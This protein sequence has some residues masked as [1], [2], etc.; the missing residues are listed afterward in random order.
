MLE[1]LTLALR[2]WLVY[3]IGC[4]EIVRGELVRF[5]DKAVHEHQ[6]PGVPV[7]KILCDSVKAWMSLCRESV[8]S[9]RLLADADSVLLADRI[10]SRMS[11][12]ALHLG[13]FTI[14]AVGSL[15]PVGFRA[16][17]EVLPDNIRLQ[18]N[19]S[20]Q[21]WPLKLMDQ[22]VEQL[23]MDYLMRH[24]FDSIPSGT[25]RSWKTLNRSM[26]RLVAAMEIVLSGL[27]LRVP[28]MLNRG[29]E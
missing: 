18:P 25:S 7:V 3:Q 6:G 24:Q 10:E 11:G 1:A 23:V 9:L 21:Y 4:K 20:R 19:F 28:N 16:W 29:S 14:D 27:N 2:Q 13:I 12:D 8:V 17:Y 5:V 15:Q 26:A 22:D